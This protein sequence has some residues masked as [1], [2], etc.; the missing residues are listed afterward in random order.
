MVEAARMKEVLV[1]LNS[2]IGRCHI[3]RQAR[4][5]PSKSTAPQWLPEQN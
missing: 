1:G 5:S 3:Y 4:R 2:Q